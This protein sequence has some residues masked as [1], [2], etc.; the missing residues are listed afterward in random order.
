MGAPE[1]TEQTSFSPAKINAATFQRSFSGRFISL[2]L[3][4][5]GAGVYAVCVMVR[6]LFVVIWVRSTTAAA[7]LPRG[8]RGGSKGKGQ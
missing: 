7:P 1:R 2:R 5:Q 6:F 8:E 3:Q 4:A